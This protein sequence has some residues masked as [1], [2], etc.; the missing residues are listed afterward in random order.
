MNEVE[1]LV[2]SSVSV[3]AH[4]ARVFINL[5]SLFSLCNGT[6][7]VSSKHCGALACTVYIGYMGYANL[8]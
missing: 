3:D 6:C 2:K 8:L 7:M 5:E 4:P 1:T